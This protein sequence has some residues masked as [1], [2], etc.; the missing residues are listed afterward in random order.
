MYFFHYAVAGT[1]RKYKE[2][3]TAQIPSTGEAKVNI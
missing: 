2:K 1:F 3:L